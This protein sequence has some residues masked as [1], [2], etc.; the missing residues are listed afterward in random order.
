MKRTYG[1]IST[2]AKGR[3]YVKKAKAK[4]VPR[5]RRFGAVSRPL[6]QYSSGFPKQ[7][8][9]THRYVQLISQIF[10]GPSLDALYFPFGVNCLYDPYLALGG[11]Q[12]LYFDQMTA[13][14]NHYTVMKSRLKATI[15]PNT[16]DPFVGG[17]YIDD[18][19]NP[20]TRLLSNIMEQPSSA[21][22]MSQRDTTNLI[23]YKSWDCK[24]VF[25][26]NPL[27]N[28]KLQGTIST[29][30]DEYQSFIIYMRPLLGDVVS[31]Q[32]QVAIEIEFDTV[33]NELKM[34]SS[35]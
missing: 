25:G 8:H 10:T 5:Y 13:I 20:A 33:W 22:R 12:P 23:L 16:I 28:D 6:V 21:S 32:F 11:Q 1:Q 30:P 26:P 9:I 15:I 7:M 14:Y 29:N 35:S 18:D 4:S 3:P 24:S 17:I 31:M 19:F 2:P 27:D 34:M